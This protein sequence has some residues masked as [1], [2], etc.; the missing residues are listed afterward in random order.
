MNSLLK[1]TKG[2]ISIVILVIGVFAV[3]TLAI[4]TFFAS[5][6]FVSESFIGV[7]LTSKLNSQVES[8]FLEEN[9]NV[10]I[11]IGSNGEEVFYQEK[12]KEKKFFFFGDEEFEFSIEY[13]LR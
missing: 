10:D 11:I 13:P 4:L 3:C 7:G 12:V 8:Y 9:S 6:A 1:R 5:S 2:E